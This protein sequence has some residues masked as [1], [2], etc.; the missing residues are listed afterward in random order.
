MQTNENYSEIGGVVSESLVENA[1]ADIVNNQSSVSGS[2][3]TTVSDVVIPE[4]PNVADTSPQMTDAVSDIGNI[5]PTEVSNVPETNEFSFPSSA[6]PEYAPDRVFVMYDPDFARAESTAADILKDYSD[7]IPGLQLIQLPET[8]TVEE[9]IEYY[10]NLPGVIYAEPD[11][12]ISLPEPEISSEPFTIATSV[13]PEPAAETLSTSPNDPFFSYQWGL[14]NSGSVPVAGK[15]GYSFTGVTKDSDIDAMDAWRITTGSSK[16][17]VAV[18]DSGINY[19]HEDLKANMWRSSSGYYGYDFVNSDNYPMDDNGHGTHCAGIVGAVGNNGLGISGVAWDVSLMAVKVMDAAG[20]GSTSTIISGMDYAAKNGADIIS[21]SLGGYSSR[22]SRDSRSFQSAV[23]E[24]TS[25]VIVCSAGNDGTNNDVSPHYPSSCVSDNLI[26][27]A[28]SAMDDTL[29]SYSNYGR[30]SVDVAAPGDN[31][32]SASHSYDNMYLYSSGTSMAA[33]MVSGIAA[34]MLSEN[35]DLSA[36][37]V[38]SILKKTVDTKSALSGK[39]S[40]GGRVKAAQNVPTPT[41]TPTPTP[42]SA[43]SSWSGSGTRTDPYLIESPEDLE[44]LVM[45]VNYGGNLYRGTYFQLTQDLDLSK[46]CWDPIGTPTN[47]FRGTF[48]GDG[49]TIHNLYADQKGVLRNGLFGYVRGATLTNIKIQGGSVEGGK[50]VGGLVGYVLTSAGDTTDINNCS[51]DV[52]VTSEYSEDLAFIG[53]LIG[54]IDS[55]GTCR[56][57]DCCVTQNVV[58][59]NWGVDAWSDNSEISSVGGLVGYITSAG[60]LTIARCSTTGDV[61]VTFDSTSPPIN[62][63]G[64]EYEKTNAGGLIGMLVTS[65][66]PVE[67]TD[68]SVTGTVSLSTSYRYLSGGGDYGGI[69]GRMNAAVPVTVRNC[70]VS[71]NIHYTYIYITRGLVAA[72]VLLEAYREPMGAL[73]RFRTVLS[74][75]NLSSTGVGM[76]I[77]ALRI[78]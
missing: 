27:V 60:P 44:M 42:T 78:G 50:Y 52:S 18:L 8:V 71:G 12:Y 65:L 32:V 11:Y 72:G 5:E 43:P 63:S 70:Y 36:Q 28:A 69:I 15:P 47:P 61:L 22:D 20:K 17:V 13:L 57:A 55:K 74:Y 59:T 29:S 67:I 38:V 35:P 37:E 54:Y 34:L 53:G 73:S 3:N 41:V 1:S 24:I 62:Y 48:D 46:I 21:M 23:D 9:A 45:Q 39:I 19:N 58:Y 56:I 68:C 64:V 26:A 6:V 40:T 33:P 49:H 4:P 14:E 66:K 77:S 75:L 25:S 51:V 30:T 31:I 10:S 2:K 16:V 7:F 76:I